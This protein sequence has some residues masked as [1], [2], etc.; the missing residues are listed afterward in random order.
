MDGMPPLTLGLL[1]EMR[2]DTM[3]EFAY[4]LAVAPSWRVSGRW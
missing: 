3:I 1:R 2:D 4:F